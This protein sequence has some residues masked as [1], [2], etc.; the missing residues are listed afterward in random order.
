MEFIWGRIGACVCFVEDFC[1][2]CW[3]SGRRLLVG[4][5]GWEQVSKNEELCR[6]L[7]VNFFLTFNWICLVALLLSDTENRYSTYAPDL[8]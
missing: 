1:L 2:L 8:F 6:K 3:G 4:K 5:E 7:C